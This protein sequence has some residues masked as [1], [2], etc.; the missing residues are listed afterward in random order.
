MADRIDGAK[1]ADWP[2]L[3]TEMMYT[4]ETIEKAF[5]QTD[6]NITKV[7]SVERKLIDAQYRLINKMLDGPESFFSKTLISIIT[8]SKAIRDVYAYVNR[9]D[10]VKNGGHA[11]V[12]V[13]ENLAGV[14]EN[15]TRMAALNSLSK[16]EATFITS[17]FLKTADKEWKELEPG[18]GLVDLTKFVLGLVPVDIPNVFD[19]CLTKRDKDKALN[20]SLQSRINSPTPPEADSLFT[21]K[22]PSLTPTPSISSLLDQITYEQGRAQSGEANC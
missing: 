13:T 10:A 9:L 18:G 11:G 14:F 2:E 4:F 6:N 3:W 17:Q 19:K 21:A 7:E 16:K 22:L 12:T 1:N 8:T 5:K 15:I 20:D